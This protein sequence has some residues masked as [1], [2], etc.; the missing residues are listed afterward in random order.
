MV[1]QMGQQNQ[2]QPSFVRHTA[3]AISTTAAARQ[4]QA[5][6]LQDHSATFQELSDDSLGWP[7]VQPEVW[8]RDWAPS[9]PLL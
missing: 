4:L 9:V 6:T 8:N 7:M 5:G 1:K 2:A 3:Q